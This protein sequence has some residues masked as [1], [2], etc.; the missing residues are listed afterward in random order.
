MYYLLKYNEDS[1]RNRECGEP[2][3]R[4]RIPEKQENEEFKLKQ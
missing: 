3:E 4:E 1:I 2:S